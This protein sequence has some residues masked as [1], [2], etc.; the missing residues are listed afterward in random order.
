MT[1]VIIIFIALLFFIEGLS[2]FILVKHVVVY[3][4]LYMLKFVESVRKYILPQLGILGHAFTRRLLFQ[5]FGY[6]YDYYK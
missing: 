6:G 1:R 4:H 5:Y 2:I 3:H